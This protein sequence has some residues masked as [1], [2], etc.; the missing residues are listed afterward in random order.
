MAPIRGANQRD[1]TEFDASREA[2]VGIS[3]PTIRDKGIYTQ[4]PDET[5][6]KRV[7]EELDDDGQL[8]YR[9]MFEDH[10]T[11]IVSHLYLHLESLSLKKRSLSHSPPHS[12]AMT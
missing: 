2:F 6:V 1:D 4:N 8:S 11:E 9:V 12:N 5:T 10:H 7:E 3:L